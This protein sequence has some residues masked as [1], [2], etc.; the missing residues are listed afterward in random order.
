MDHKLKG[1]KK[2]QSSLLSIWIMG[3]MKQIRYNNPNN[4]QL[5]GWKKEPQY[6]K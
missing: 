4:L 2:V 6:T 1:I 3:N 5:P